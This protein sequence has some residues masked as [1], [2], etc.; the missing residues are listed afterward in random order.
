MKTIEIKDIGEVVIRELD[1]DDRE[2]LQN[3]G[4]DIKMIPIPNT[5]KFRPVSIPKIGTINKYTFILGIAKAPF[6]TEEIDKNG[7]N[8]NKLEKRLTEYKNINYKIVETIVPHIAD[9]NQIDSEE[10]KK[11]KENLQ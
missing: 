5:N 2:I 6:F 3:K 10:L 7:F 11:L 4:T 9:Y 1:N 8:E